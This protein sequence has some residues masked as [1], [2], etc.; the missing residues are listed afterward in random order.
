MAKISLCTVKNLEVAAERR[1]LKP[2][3]VDEILEATHGYLGKKLEYDAFKFNCEHFV[4]GC[5]FG[6][7]F[8]GQA[9]AAKS[10]HT[11]KK[12][13]RLVVNR[14]MSA[15]ACS[16]GTWSKMRLV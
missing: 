1:G 15:E 3:K 4:T 9:E 7:C 2:R 11:V 14:Y 16:C 10:K 5:Y 12:C 8:S 6:V 13:T